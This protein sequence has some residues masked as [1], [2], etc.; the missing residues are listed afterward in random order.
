[1]IESMFK[2]LI[3][4]HS[5]STFHF[6]YGYCS[7]IMKSSVFINLLYCIDKEPM[8]INKSIVEYMCIYMGRI[9]CLVN[10]TSLW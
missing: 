7:V 6:L 10:I 1:M 9:F 4:V 2:N 5:E 3:L 8:H